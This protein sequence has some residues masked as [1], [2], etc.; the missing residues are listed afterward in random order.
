MPPSGA[1]VRFALG[2]KAWLFART[3]RGADRA[4]FIGVSIRWGTWT[5]LFV[6]VA[7]DG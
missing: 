3:D 4:T 1:L 2:K 6:F 5:D 7:V